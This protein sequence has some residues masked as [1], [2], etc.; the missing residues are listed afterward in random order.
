[1]QETPEIFKS[2][3]YIIIE[4]I[5]YVP[6]SVL[7]RTIIKKNSGNVSAVSLD[8][9][10]ELSEKIIPFDT[11]IQIIDGEAE[12][13]I[14]GVAHYLSTGQAIVIPAHRLHS[15]NAKERFKMIVTVIKSGYED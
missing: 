8:S 9:G 11:F 1:M 3:V 14:D 10:M 4:I 6:N 7:S 2:Q 13:L 15:F 12:I 5:E